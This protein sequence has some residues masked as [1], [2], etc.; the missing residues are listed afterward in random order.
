MAEISINVELTRVNVVRCA[1]GFA[2]VCEARTNALLGDSAI[3]RL[4]LFIVEGGASG[5][6]VPHWLSTYLSVPTVP[7][8]LISAYR[9]DLNGFTPLNPN[10]IINMSTGDLNCEWNKDRNRDQQ[11]QCTA[12]SLPHP[13]P[14]GRSVGA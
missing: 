8:R 13:V 2:V 9:Q 12:R 10:F 6:A 1:N 11:S 14:Y 5:L 4:H 7:L 3:V